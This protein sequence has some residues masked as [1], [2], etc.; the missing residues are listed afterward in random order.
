MAVVSQAVGVAEEDVVVIKMTRV[1]TETCECLRKMCL[2][3]MMDLFVME[4]T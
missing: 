3:K 2:E 4:F 1:L